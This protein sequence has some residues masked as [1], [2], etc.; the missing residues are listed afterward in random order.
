MF[1]GQFKNAVDEKGRVAI[2][3]RH[4]EVLKS[5]EED[6][7][8]VTYHF[9]APNPCLDVWPISEWKNLTAKL[10]QKEGSFGKARTLF[11]S[12]YIGQAVSCQLDRQGRILIPQSLRERARLG[13][14]VTFVGSRNKVR[15]WGAQ[16]YEAIVEGYESM[17]TDDPD[18]LSDLGI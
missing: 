18:A 7:V 12:V 14:E 4:R 9:V 16:F 11:E 15:V 17:M 5:L 3:A 8:M 13:E 10:D 1:E 2:P 6:R